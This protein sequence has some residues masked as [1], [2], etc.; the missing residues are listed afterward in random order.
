[1]SILRFRSCYVIWK[2]YYVVIRWISIEANHM[3]CTK[4]YL[5]GYNLYYEY[6]FGTNKMGPDIYTEW[7]KCMTHMIRHQRVASLTVSSCCQVNLCTVIYKEIFMTELRR[8]VKML[9]SDLILNV[10]Q[11]DWSIQSSQFSLQHRHVVFHH[12]LF[13]EF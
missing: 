11:S 1:M 4:I 7:L 13:L 3:K 5:K 10:L 2:D 12:L 8:Y 6:A 9:H